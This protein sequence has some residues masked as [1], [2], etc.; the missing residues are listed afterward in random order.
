MRDRW[1]DAL[2]YHTCLRSG[3]SVTRI[4][5]RCAAAAL[6]PNSS[7]AAHTRTHLC[8]RSLSTHAHAHSHSTSHATSTSPPANAVSVLKEW[9]KHSHNVTVLSGAGISTASGIPGMQ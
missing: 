2:S 4:A 8:V 6:N 3:V 7:I 9:L 5:G 1:R